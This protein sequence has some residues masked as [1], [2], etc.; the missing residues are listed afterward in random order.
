MQVVGPLATGNSILSNRIYDN[1]GL[2]IDNLQN[3]P[4]ITSAK[5]SGGISGTLDSTPD[6]SFSV[7]CFATGGG[8]AS[9]HGEGRTLLGNTQV[10]TDAEGNATFDCAPS[11]PD[12]VQAVSATATNEA[13]GGTSEFSANH[14]VEQAALGEGSWRGRVNLRAIIAGFLAP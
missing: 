9:E 3:F 11:V 5:T 4:E 6:Q 12:T 1:R 2:G 8:G 7:Q 13:T 14:A 10:T